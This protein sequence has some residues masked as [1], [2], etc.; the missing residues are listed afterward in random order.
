MNCDEFEYALPQDDPENNAELKAHAESCPSCKEQMEIRM[1]MS[2]L[3]RQKHTAWDSPFL[4]PKIRNSLL[5]EP[6][7]GQSKRQA[8]FY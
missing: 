6:A 2:R 4:W 5:S 3:A 8:R 1:E 7:Y